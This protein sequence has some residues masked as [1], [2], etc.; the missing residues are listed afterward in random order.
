MSYSLRL[1][2]TVLGVIVAVLGLGADH[3]A[4][5]PAVM[6][7]TATNPEARSFL[8]AFVYFWTFFTH[9]TNL[10]LLL[11]YVAA[12][13]TWRWLGWFRRPYTLASAAAFITLVL[14]FY[15]F[16]L[17]PTVTLEG[18]LGFGSIMLHYVAPVLYLV[19]WVACAPHGELRFGQLPLMLLPGA[20]Y[21]VWVLARGA[22][23]NEYPYDILDAGQ[24]GYGHV[25]SG[26]AMVLAA[27]LVFSIVLILVDAWLGRRKRAA[28]GA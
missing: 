27:V 2:L 1:I 18:L 14:L 3:I 7:V 28:S 24:Y 12:L 21:L 8:G 4:V 22:V 20:I 26:V 10:W 13:T 5:F 17:L 19:W 11:I 25:A 16:I 23:V 15:H 6:T 9:L